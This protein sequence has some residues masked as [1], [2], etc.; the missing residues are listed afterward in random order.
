MFIQGH[1]VMKL[2]SYKLY[3]SVSLK[4]HYISSTIIVVV[5]LVLVVV[6]VV[7]VVVVIVVVVVNHCFTSPLL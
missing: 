7:V 1:F 4:I 5:V 2:N 3:D 6:V